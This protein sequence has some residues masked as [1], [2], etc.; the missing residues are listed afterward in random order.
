MNSKTEK[1]I[2]N[3][4]WLAKQGNLQKG[5]GHMDVWSKADREGR[6]RLCNTKWMSK[7]ILIR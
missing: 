1:D 7:R 5:F 3:E 4:R 6:V 2:V